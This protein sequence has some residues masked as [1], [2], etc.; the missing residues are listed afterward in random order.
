[1]R[2][3]SSPSTTRPIAG[4]V[5]FAVALTLF[6]ATLAAPAPAA[7]ARVTGEPTA[8]V[9][10][11]VVSMDPSD[12][13]RVRRRQTVLVRDGRIVE[14]GPSSQIEVPDDATVVARGRK[15]FVVPGLADTHVHHSSV[16]RLPEEVS[17]EDLYALYLANGV[18]TLFDL[19]GFPGIF[20]WRRDIERGR[21]VGPALF[22]TGPIIDEVFYP[23]VAALEADMR[24]WARQGYAY[25]KSHTITTPAFFERLHEIARE[26]GIPVVGHALR[27]GFPI[28]DTLAE[29]PLMIAHVEEIYSTSVTSLPTAIAELEEPVRDVAASRAWVNT[30]L[31]IYETV[32]NTVDDAAFAALLARPEMRYVPPSVRSFWEF[33]NRF[34]V[35]NFG[36]RAGWL[37]ALA[38]QQ[39]IVSELRRLDSL[40]RLLAG[41]DAFGVPNIVPGFSLHDELALLV[42]SGLTPWEAIATATY[43]AAAFFETLDEVGTVT[44]GRRADLLVVRKNPLRR[45]G[46]LRSPVGVMVNGLWLP[47][48]EL[49]ERLDEI[50]ARWA[51]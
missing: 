28:Q 49:Q 8:L 3:P 14:V 26:L 32:A 16:P 9:N 23:G 18:T 12:T 15:F 31:T 43:N 45:I 33:N 1:M 19:S 21:V 38:A 36:T 39:F 4:G 35:P 22:F 7:A 29:G 30:T 5:A 24:R 37:Q 13:Q 40:D 27:P 44:A 2:L 46:R 47:A 20:K 48:A 51:E 10:V 34:R 41:T 6:G 42:G 25:M 17:P 50:A 11:S